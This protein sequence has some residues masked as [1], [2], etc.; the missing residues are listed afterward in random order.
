MKNFT[1]LFCLLLLI[2]CKSHEEK[3]ALESDTIYES[4]LDTPKVELTEQQKYLQENGFKITADFSESQF[5]EF[6]SAIETGLF[7]DESFCDVFRKGLK[8]E[9]NKLKSYLRKYKAIP[10][11]ETL[12][13]M[14]GYKV[15][16]ARPVED[17]NASNTN[18][19]NDD[20]SGNPCV[21]SEDFIKQDLRHPDT[22]D[23]SMFDCSTEKNS[24]GSFTI[25][26]KVS[27]ENAFGVKSSFI[28]KV[29]LGF[30]GGEWTDTSN[31]DLINI[32]SEEYR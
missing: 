8:L 16:D 31:W 30:K 1:Y 13:F 20:S 28:Y 14:Y 32:R 25:L 5:K 21:I 9:G 3:D 24:D 10:A 23:F 19:L 26:R 7:K 17:Y 2:G 12:L 4:P 18:Y 15:C 22:A 6:K 29:K 11:F 27:A